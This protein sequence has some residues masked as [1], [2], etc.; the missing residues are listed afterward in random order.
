MEQKQKSGC[1]IPDSPYM[2]AVGLLIRVMRR[3]HACVERRIGDLGIHHGQHRML[4]KLACRQEDIPSQKEL[5]EIMG[6]S[7]AAVTTTLKKLEREEYIS[8]SMT[9]ED[10]RKNEIRI[11][12]KGLSKVVESR[13][14]FEST[15]TE[16]FAGFTPE[17]IATFISFME[18][19]DRNLDAAGAPAD[20]SAIPNSPRDRKEV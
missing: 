11:T 16:M 20:P 12:E 18:R 5:A 1:P 14:V 10:N 9:D 15:D 2:R 19:L 3:H 4:M 6:I 7:P 8:R 17:E 13:A